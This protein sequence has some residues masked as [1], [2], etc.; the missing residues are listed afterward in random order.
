MTDE[1]KP[2]LENELLTD[3]AKAQLTEAWQ[4]K[5]EEAREEIEVTL[6]E[7]FASRYEHDKGCLLEAVERMVED[8]L[9]AEIAEFVQDRNSLTEQRV[10][11]ANE[12]REARVEAKNKLAEQMELLEKFV[13]ENL[14]KELKEFQT[15]RQE[16][17]EAKKELAK[18]LRESRV[19]SKKQLAERIQVIEQFVLEN[20]KT[21]LK[22]FQEDKQALVNQRV[23][24]IE[25][26]KAKINETRKEF[27][28]RSAKL[29][30]EKLDGILTN[31]MTQ[32]KED[33]QA[34]RKKHFGMTLF[35]AFASE[36][37]AT[38]FNENKEVQKLRKQVAESEQKLTQA[39]ELFEK[40]QDIAKN[41]QQRQQLAESRAE[42]TVVMNELLSKL[43]GKQRE[44]M[45]EL[46]EGVRTQ[47][48]RTSF[49]KYIPAVT[50]GSG[51]TLLNRTTLSENKK[52]VTGDKTN[53]LLET[54][55]SDVQ[56]EDENEAAEI[57][58]LRRLAGV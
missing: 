57:V 30:E 19:A 28:R 12:I 25:Q 40:A 42:R 31:E 51:G 41:A 15:D 47:N 4:K 10:K 1:L 55:Q 58:K 2:L 35:E 20:L 16:V 22:E 36:Y 29:V 54:A 38:F 48:L 21:E 52:V 14:G 6:R 53:K 7:E 46:L 3:E 5:L 11:L 32:F 39:A 43:S 34:S 45:S 27:I 18:Q 56:A 9:K 37:Q 13:L 44:V 50:S 8:G 17:R 24:M 49:K 23:K 33:I 26:G